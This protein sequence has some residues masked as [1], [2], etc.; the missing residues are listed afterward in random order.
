MKAQSIQLERMHNDEHFQF[1]TEFIALLN[2]TGASQLKVEALFE[3]YMT[4]YK[5]ADAALKK[6]LK[7]ELTKEIQK[8]DKRR[9]NAFLGLLKKHRICLK[10]FQPEVQQAA[11]KLSIPLNTYGNLARKSLNK[12]SSAVYN[13]MQELRGAYAEALFTAGLQEWAD[14]LE[15]ANN[16]FMDLYR[17]RQDETSQKPNLKLFQE[18]KN[19]DKAYRQLIQHLNAHLLLE[20]APLYVDFINSLNT[21]TNKYKTLMAQRAGKA[22][23]KR[24]RASLLPPE[25]V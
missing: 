22:K 20:G 13:L 25:G 2:R 5:R 10:H 8:A 3:A 23:A 15:T 17:K 11:E 1:H 16:D 9:D 4:F 18:R 24:Q 19:M 21:L 12:Q 6:I 14:E 7:S